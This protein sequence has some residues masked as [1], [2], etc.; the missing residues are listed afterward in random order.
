MPDEWVLTLFT[1]WNGMIGI[2]LV[3]V[4]LIGVVYIVHNVFDQPR[5]LDYMLKAVFYYILAAAIYR[6]WVTSTTAGGPIASIGGFQDAAELAYMVC[7]L[8]MFINIFRA[9]VGGPNEQGPGPQ[10]APGHAPGHAPPQAPG[11]HPQHPGQQ[12]QP[13]GQQPQPPG[14]PPG[15][16]TL[17][18][19]Q[20]ALLEQWFQQAMNQLGG[21][22]AQYQQDYTA[23]EA[24]MRNVRVAA[25]ITPQHHQLAALLDRNATR[26]TNNFRL[27][28]N[29]PH[30]HFLSQQSQ[31]TFANAI[32][33]WTQ[34]YVQFANLRLRMRNN[35]GVVI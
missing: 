4:P 20:I 13:P 16:P 33:Q 1:V 29:Y 27:I 3:V 25:D 12:P 30:F 11:Q 14:Q 8:I 9:I 23:F 18:P 19:Q 6:L 32:Q 24:A 26:I 7:L 15:P 31:Q 22:I 17:T 21:Q 34:L 2:I 10:A 28:A 5:R 35:T